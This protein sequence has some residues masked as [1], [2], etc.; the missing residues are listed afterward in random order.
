MCMAVCMEHW[1]L[2]IVLVF[3]IETTL[4]WIMITT[5]RYMQDELAIRYTIVAQDGLR[6][7]NIHMDAPNVRIFHFVGRN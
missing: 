6:S 1:I 4:D 3:L 2:L 5:V 7:Q